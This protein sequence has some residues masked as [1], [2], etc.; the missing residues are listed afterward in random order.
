MSITPLAQ[1]ERAYRQS[2]T[3][4]LGLRDKFGLWNHAR[5]DAKRAVPTVVGNGP[6]DWNTVPTWKIEASNATKLARMTVL[7]LLIS[8]RAELRE[9]DA[10]RTRLEVE[11]RLL[12]TLSGGGQDELVEQTRRVKRNI[13]SIERQIPRLESHLANAAREATNW[14]SLFF[15]VADHRVAYYWRVLRRRHPQ[16]E[17]FGN[18]QPIIPR[19]S[20]LSTFSLE[21]LLQLR[22]DG[23]FPGEAASANPA[24]R[25]EE[26]P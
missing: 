24:A 6:L 2:G 11:T 20:W 9:Y 16:G 23:T 4:N 17:N 14:G 1:Q 19:P 13:S 15:D 12:G 21:D 18:A 3:V 22:E 26:R 10:L 7:G 25:Q 8:C 5:L